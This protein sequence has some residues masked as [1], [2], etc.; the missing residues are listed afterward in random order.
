MGTH[1]FNPVPMMR[2]LELVR[3]ITTSDETLASVCAFGESL[4]RN[5]NFV[6]IDPDLKD[7]WGIP[8]LHISMEQGDN[9]HNHE[10]EVA[11]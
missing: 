3:A 11:S 4:A 8:A 10:S 7:A 9:E 1:F 2:L 6:S 5:S